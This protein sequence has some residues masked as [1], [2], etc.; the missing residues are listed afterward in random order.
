MRMKLIKLLALWVMFSGVSASGAFAQEITNFSASL[1]GDVTSAN[2]TS[3]AEHTMADNTDTGKVSLSLSSKKGN[4]SYITYVYEKSSL[5]NP[6]TVK[7]EYKIQNEQDGGQSVAL[8]AFMDPLDI[9]L[10]KSV[11]LVYSGNELKFPK[12]ITK[13]Q[14]LNN[15]TGNYTLTI[16]GVDNFKKNYNVSLTNVIVNAI[17]TKKVN[18]NTYDAYEISFNYLNKSSFNGSNDSTKRHSVQGY[19]IPSLG[20][21]QTERSG[22]NDMNDVTINQRSTSSLSK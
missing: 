9:Y 14:S 19:F 1:S 16:P 22:T 11:E 15:V 3:T 21:V 13:G 4:V 17:T 18:G 8:D 2:A 12:N 5:P 10:D 20:F 7:H 6:Y